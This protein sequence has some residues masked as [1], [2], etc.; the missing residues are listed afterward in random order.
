MVPAIFGVIGVLVGGSITTIGNLLLFRRQ[1]EAA[2]RADVLADRA[3]VRAERKAAYLR[4]LTAARRLR[5]IAR[6]AHSADA[7][8]IDDLRTEIS[9]TQY[10]IELIASYEIAEAANTL[11][12][13]TL[14]YLNAA[15]DGQPTDEPR[16]EARAAVSALITTAQRDL[17]DPPVSTG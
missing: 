14:D 2:A 1:Q 12:R 13:K 8:A 7:T 3:R 15:R 17:L 5:Y 6:N 16:R 11:R 9:T 4:L 10:E